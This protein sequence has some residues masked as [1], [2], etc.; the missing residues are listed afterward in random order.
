MK[1]G[2]GS[3]VQR[4]AGGQEKQG[5]YRPYQEDELQRVGGATKGKHITGSNN[6]LSLC[7]TRSQFKTYLYK[8]EFLEEGE[9]ISW[10]T[11]TSKVPK[12]ESRLNGCVRWKK[13]V[14]EIG[15]GGWSPGVQCLQGEVKLLE[16]RA[17]R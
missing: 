12:E 5:Q 7:F 1:V 17:V 10:L 3:R 8:K 14:G 2:R 4:L 11:V 15:E 16:C 13:N 9:V 6:Q